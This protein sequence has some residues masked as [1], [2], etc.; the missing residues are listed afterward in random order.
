MEHRSSAFDKR[1]KCTVFRSFCSAPLTLAS[2]SPSKIL[3]VTVVAAVVVI[4]CAVGPAVATRG[5]D[6]SAPTYENAWSCLKSS[7][8][9]YGIVRAY[10]SLGQP[11][12]K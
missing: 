6:V 4:A 11:D 10:Q 12:P 1:S 9:D 8:Y 7:G 5:V 2:M 3:S